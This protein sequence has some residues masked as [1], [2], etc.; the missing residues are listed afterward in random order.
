MEEFDIRKAADMGAIPDNV[1]EANNFLPKE[2]S[3]KIIEEIVAANVVRQYVQTLNVA[4]RSLSI[5]RILYGDSVNAYKVAYGVDVRDGNTEASFATKS[6]VLEPQLMV[7]FTTL[8]ESDLET[9]GV[10]L[11]NYIRKTLA[12]TIARAE[13]KAMLIGVEG[14]G[15]SYLSLFDG[16]YTIANDAGKCA[17]TAITYGESD[18]LCDKIGDA[19]AGQGVYGEDRG[20]LVIFAANTFANELRKSAKI[21]QVG[22]YNVAE[23]GVTRTGSLPLIHGVKVIESSVLEAKNS[24]HCAV[25]ARVDGGM[26]GQ[27]G[28]I[29]FR[30]KAIEE[31]F[32][33]LLIMAEV[34]DF[35]WAL[36]NASDKA[37]GLTLIK[38]SG[39]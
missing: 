22:T 27:R 38:K 1:S 39:S 12:M 2:V 33:V 17:Q 7:S 15:S 21:Q 26:L 37:L 28:Q 10:D 9:A 14:S 13:E 23:T 11:S 18:D 30:R 25:L 31:K 20:Q 4:G 19:I 35:V 16:I 29:I 3:A 5:P 8:L 24:G 6:V 36:Q 32:S 34:I